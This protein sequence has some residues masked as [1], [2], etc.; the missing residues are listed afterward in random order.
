MA[1]LALAIMT[2]LCGAAL[3]AGSLAASGPVLARLSFRAPLFFLGAAVAFGFS[4]RPLGLVL[5]APIA[6]AMGACAS[7]ESRWRELLAFGAILTVLCVGMF[8]FMLG[9]PIPIMPWLLGY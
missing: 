4:V 2:G 8:K 9:L 1:P 7:R 6:I 5:A 3:V